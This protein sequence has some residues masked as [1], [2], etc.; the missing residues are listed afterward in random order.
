MPKLIKS[1]VDAIKEPGIYSDTELRGFKLRVRKTVQGFTKTY[2]VHAKC[3]SSKKAIT[4]T[5]GHHN[6]ISAEQARILA[7]Q[8]LADLASGTNPNKQK[9]KYRAE[10]REHEVRL[11]LIVQFNQRT[12]RHLLAD[13]LKARPLKNET[14]K[15]YENIVK[16]VLGDWLDLPITKITRD[17]VQTRFLELSNH[18]KTQANYTMRVL[19]A[20]M[21]YAI[22]VYEDVDGKP[23][24][25]LNPV[26]R[27]R[28]ARLWHRTK[29]RQT[30]IRP[31]QL[32]VW[33]E[34]V[35]RL[36]RLDARDILLLEILTG[37]RHGEAVSLEWK[38]VDFEN[39]TITIEDTKNHLDHMIPMSSQLYK[40][41]LCRYNR[42]E[43]DIYVFPNAA[44]ACGHITDIRDSI[45]QV[46]TTSGVQFSEHDLR[47]TFETTAESLDV[48]YYTL[49]K[50][51]NHKTGSDPTAGYIV[52]SAERMREAIQ[53]I[54]DFL[55]DQMGWR[56][57]DT[58]NGEVIFLSYR[59]G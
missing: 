47:R 26:D 51:L 55:T 38:T 11:G 50:L 32:Q 27:L 17:M 21:R 15:G 33:Y 58:N 36:S 4:V 16:R 2:I 30:V 53:K 56:K 10:L 52:V 1:I 9:E 46:I 59:T 20:L 13:Y 19:R 28:D 7:I 22:S 45:K 14:K 23:L 25:M 35:M 49:K 8:T 18:S 37:L 44:S 29:R 24:L 6:I 41:L 57:D 3:R 5:L 12:L 42:R 39:G 54:A 40:L 31:T 48:S 34:G 43:S